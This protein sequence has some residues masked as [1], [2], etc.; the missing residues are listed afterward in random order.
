MPWSKPT[1]RWQR[2][3][4]QNPHWMGV[5]TEV[6]YPT[7]ERG[8]VARQGLRTS[9]LG[10]GGRSQRALT[11]EPKAHPCCWMEQ[12]AERAGTWQIWSHQFTMWSMLTHTLHRRCALPRTFF[13]I[14]LIFFSSRI[15][16]SV[17]KFHSL[18][19]IPPQE[20]Q[21]CNIYFFLVYAPPDR[22]PHHN[23]V[24]NRSH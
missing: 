14:G 12:W 10:R 4:S 23:P 20:Q 8:E 13:P 9:V 21:H 5:R 17:S 11:M 15:F 2:I 19:N 22:H 16:F 6:Q 18:E 7:P 24:P 1:G 3:T